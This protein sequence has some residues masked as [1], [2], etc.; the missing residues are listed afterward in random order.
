[1]VTTH[2]VSE[3]GSG[4]GHVTKKK[5]RY[6]RLRFEA[7]S[8]CLKRKVKGPYDLRVFTSLGSDGADGAAKP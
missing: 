3:S 6:K 7:L 1:M 8:K 4:W 5:T 2:E